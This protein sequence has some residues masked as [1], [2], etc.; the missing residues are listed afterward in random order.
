MMLNLVC[1][2]TNK[3]LYADEYKD[4]L[5]KSVKSLDEFMGQNTRKS[6][7]LSP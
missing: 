7:F 6:P 3:F 1:K 4:F 5:I 2:Y